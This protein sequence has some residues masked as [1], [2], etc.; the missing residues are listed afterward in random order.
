MR[1]ILAIII[2]GG[3]LSYKGFEEWKVSSNA[4]ST[5]SKVKTADLEKGV[6]LKNNYIQLDEHYSWIANCVYYANVDDYSSKPTA[7]SKLEYVYYPILSNENSFLLKQALLSKKYGSF[8]KIPSSKLPY[9]KIKILVKSTKYDTVGSIPLDEDHGD[10]FKGLVVNSINSL[11]DDEVAL[12]NQC[13][14]GADLSNVVI[15]EE[16]RKPSSSF[17]SLLM[18][19]GGVLI[20]LGGGAFGLK[21]LSR[22][23]A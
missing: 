9:D 3:F 16:G 15:I 18:M 21:S 6:E 10:N 12:L 2:G 11:E 19:G 14:P 13:L 4:K 1:L 20:I 7:N 17:L 8:D 5:P 22:K 23:S